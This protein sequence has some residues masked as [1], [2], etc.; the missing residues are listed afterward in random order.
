[1]SQEDLLGVLQNGLVTELQVELE[2]R[3]ENSIDDIIKKMLDLEIPTVVLMQASHLLLQ[4]IFPLLPH[5]LHQQGE[6]RYPIASLQL[7]QCSIQQA[8]GAS[9]SHTRAEKKQQLN[10]QEQK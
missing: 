7:L 8:E 10:I 4:H 3:G 1:M 5:F 2:K 9:S 6:V